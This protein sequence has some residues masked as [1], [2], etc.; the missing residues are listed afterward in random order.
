MTENK[1]G[2]L[3]FHAATKHLH[4][5][6]HYE[7]DRHHYAI[8]DCLIHEATPPEKANENAKRLVD[9]WNALSGIEHPEAVGELVETA[10]DIV[11]LAEA[12]DMDETAYKIQEGRLNALRDA[13]KKVTG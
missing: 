2:R 1:Y 12:S 7:D 10:Q 11:D 8:A 6:I 4:P 3:H 9:C 5:A 13:L